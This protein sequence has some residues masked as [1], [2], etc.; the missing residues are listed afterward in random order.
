MQCLRC[1]FKLMTNWMLSQGGFQRLR[2]VWVKAMEDEEFGFA[3]G[4]KMGQFGW[5]DLNVTCV[6]QKAHA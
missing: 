3:G 4:Q 2:I 5:I 6:R 1:A